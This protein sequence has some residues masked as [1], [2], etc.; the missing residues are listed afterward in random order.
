MEGKIIQSSKDHNPSM[1]GG[2]TSIGY[3]K[4]IFYSLYYVNRIGKTRLLRILYLYGCDLQ[5]QSTTA[6]KKQGAIDQ[7][8]DY[9]WS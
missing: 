1:F 2:L 3:K 8:V 9:P 4:I 6:I 5:R 7:P